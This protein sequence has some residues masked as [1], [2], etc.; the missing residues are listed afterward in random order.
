MVLRSLFANLVYSVPLG[1]T[2]PASRYLCGAPCGAC[3]NSTSANLPLACVSVVVVHKA[4]LRRSANEEG[5]NRNENEERTEERRRAG[6]GP[7]S[8]INPHRFLLLLLLL[9]QRR[10]SP[11][12]RATRLRPLRHPPLLSPRSSLLRSLSS[13]LLTK[14]GARMRVADKERERGH[15]S[16]IP[17][18][19]SSTSPSF[20]PSSRRPAGRVQFKDNFARL[21]MRIM[22]AEN[23]GHEDIGHSPQMP[24]GDTGHSLGTGL[25]QRSCKNAGFHSPFRLCLYGP[26]I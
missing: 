25:W 23:V 6:G 1:E 5:E 22:L 18:S 20:M 26:R 2:L 3:S 15:E 19:S 11:V 10:R 17:S 13:S 14:I 4:L 9:F 21:F 16:S 7:H 12:R 8:P 24:P